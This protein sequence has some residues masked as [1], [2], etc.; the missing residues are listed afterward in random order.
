VGT[1]SRMGRVIACFAI[2]TG[3]MAYN[4]V[5]SVEEVPVFQHTL[6]TSIIEPTT[7]TVVLSSGNVNIGY[8][9][10]DQ[11]A[12][13]AS[14]KEASGKN[15][16]VEYF[17][18]KLVIEQKD[19]HVSIRE[20]EGVPSLLGS[21]SSINY[22]IDVPYRTAVDSTISGTGDQTLA[23]VYGPAKLVSGTGDIN[24]K[25]VRFAPVYANT[26]KGN[27]SCSRDFE[28]N[29][30]TGDGNITLLED[31][32][33]KAVVRSGHGKIDIGGARGTVAGSTD[34]GSIHIKAVL[35]DDWQLK[36]GS[37]SIHIEL[38]PKS[39]FELEASSDSGEID[40]EREDLEK[41][42]AQIHRLHQQV[43]GGGKHI[44]VHSAKGSIFIE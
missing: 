42:Q 5:A 22:R 29:A 2:A 6:V 43:N 11:V 30:E 7:L 1:V 16:P 3:A 26:G 8:S 44:T 38:P 35:W 14:G 13:Y 40:V 37:G 20:A 32:N 36:S 15:L 18:S 27:I 41:P 12:I 24:A 10:D 9:R 33:S 19:N 21:L 31:R 17:K 23:G 4:G 39:K 28:V 34:T 25:Y